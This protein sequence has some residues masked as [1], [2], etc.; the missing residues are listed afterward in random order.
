MK[1]LYPLSGRTLRSLQKTLLFLLIANSYFSFA[2][3]GGKITGGILD[4]KKQALP[5]ANV[6]LLKAKDSTLAKATV[7]DANGKFEFFQI[8]DNQYLVSITMV[9]YEKYLSPKITISAENKDVNLP[10]I[11]MQ[12]MTKQLKEVTVSAKKPFIEQKID[13]LVVNVENSIIATGNSALEVLQKSPGITIDNND[14]ISLKGKQ[15]VQIY[16]D[17]KPTYLSQSDLTNLLKNMT[18]EQIEKIEI[19]T[20]PSSRYDAAG[21]SGIINIVTRKDKNFGTNGTLS[22]GFGASLLPFDYQY[23]LTKESNYKEYELEKPG[24]IPKGNLGL[25]LNNRKGKVNTFANLTLSD[26]RN[27]QNNSIFRTIEGIDIDQY[28]VEQRF[29]RNFG[30]KLGMDYFANKKTTV[31][32]LVNGNIGDWGQTEPSVNKSYFFDS[33]RKLQYSPQTT[34]N[35]Y[36]TWKSGIFN[37]NFKHTFDSTGKELTADFDFSVYDN[38]TKE[39]GMTT[40][41]YNAEGAEYGRPLNVTSNIPN[42]YTIT[43]A[44][45]DYILPLASIKSKFEMG[46]KTSFVKSDNNIMFYKNEEVDRGRTNHFIY[47]E[48]INAI[49]A[50]FS[51]EFNEKWSLQ[52]GLRVEHWNA[53]G[54]SLTLKEVK[55]REQ[56]QFFP[57]VFLSQKINKNNSLNYSYSRRIERPD[58]ESLN[59][60]IYFLDP[61]T[62]QVGNEFL[63]PQFANSFEVAHTFKDAIITT[64]GYSF[65]TDMMLE[66]V[67]NA[68]DDPILLEKITKYSIEQEV[69][70]KKI[71]FA[72][73][74]NLKRFENYSLNISFP[75]P[76]AKWWMANNNITAYYNRYDGNLLNQN[77]S[78]GAFAYNFFSS[79]S[80]TLKKGITAEIS[81]WYNS[82][83]VYGMMMGRPQGAV[84]L[85]VQKSFWDKKGTLKLSVN[86]VFLT[87]Y[88]NGN[89]D[90]AGVVLSIRNRWDARVARLSFTYKFGNQQVKSARRR[91]T[92]TESEQ[93]RVKSGN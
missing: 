67:K 16:M 44:K 85:G 90:F 72:T 10:N 54:E 3:S 28:T 91:S 77:L 78:V 82:A 20:N 50:N 79:H 42:Q 55:K 89:A 40:R 87:S 68:K 57:S 13:K 32:F 59:P 46:A 5:F 14:R 45:V 69:D 47:S 49:Y 75:I 38:L 64:V 31:G 33:Q 48:N 81:G 7:A 36:Q 39:L 88:W 23:G 25:N 61:Y 11:E 86:D 65:T 43:A 2:Q 27:F 6:L 4:E 22:A 21:N 62:Y 26:R 76:I 92:A 70:P 8:V 51:K 35:N 80:L 30:Y 37:L 73:K 41:F 84:N 52:T 53:K 9:G 34:S 15:G 17:G 1:K 12:L 60:F 74:D 66:V 29:S 63:K 19:I 71:T 93:G 58:Y 24:F 18:S 56:V 83:N